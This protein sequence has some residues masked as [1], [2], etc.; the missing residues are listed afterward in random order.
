MSSTNDMVE[1]LYD[2]LQGRFFGKFPGTVISNDDK[3]NRAR[4]KV[5]VPGVMQGQEIWALPC[6]PYAGAGVGLYAVP[7]EGANIWVEF[8]GG[9]PSHPVWVGCFWADG[10]TDSSENKPTNLVLRTGDCSVVID[11]E[12]GTITLTGGDGSS[13]VLGDSGITLDGTEINQSANGS[14]LGLSASGL[15]ALNGAFTVT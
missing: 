5:S 9:D 7:P 13:I 10:Q 1:D 3:Q 11:E 14:K 4:L 6:V 2:V 15:D 12:A 8:L